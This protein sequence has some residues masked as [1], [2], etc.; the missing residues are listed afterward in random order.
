[1]N[2]PL[3]TALNIGL[4]WVHH[5]LEKHAP[6]VKEGDYAPT[7]DVCAGEG[8]LFTADLKK[9]K[10]ANCGGKGQTWNNN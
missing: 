10:C 1:M 4:D 2:N 5:A 8:S 6:I 7:C 3:L 9:M